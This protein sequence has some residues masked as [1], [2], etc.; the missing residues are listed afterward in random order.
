MP[1]LSTCIITDTKILDKKNHISD[2]IS[3]KTPLLGVAFSFLFFYFFF[4]MVGQ[5][6]LAEKFM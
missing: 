1:E 2:Q 6:T 5:T 3:V 4:N